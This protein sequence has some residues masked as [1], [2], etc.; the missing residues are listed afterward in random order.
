[1]ASNAPLDPQDI[2][3]APSVS[4]SRSRAEA[5]HRLQMGLLGLGAIVLMVGLAQVVM[6]RAMEA[7]AH[8]V[9]EAA[10]TVAPTR[11]A[12]PNDPLA[13]AG[14]VPDP[15]PA[16]AGTSGPGRTGGNGPAAPPR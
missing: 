11:T 2:D 9:P 4:L 7:E 13:D 6:E 16:S 12:S 1:M 3:E 8:T 5:V 10:A 14:V 15:H